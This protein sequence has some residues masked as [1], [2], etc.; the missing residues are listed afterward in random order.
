MISVQLAHFAPS[1]RRRFIPSRQDSKLRRILLIISPLTLLVRLCQSFHPY[2]KTSLRKSNPNVNQ[3]QQ[4]WTPSLLVLVCLD[5]LL[6]VLVNIINS[7]LRSAIVPKPLK[8]AVIKS[9]LNKN[10]LDSILWKTH[11]PVLNLPYVSKLLERVLAEQ[12]VCH[13]N[14]HDLLD[15]FQS[16]YRAGHSCEIAIPRVLN[17]VL[18]RADGGTWCFSFSWTSLLHLTPLTMKFSWRNCMR[19]WAFPVLLISGFVHIWLT[20]PSMSQ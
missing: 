19:R 12:L 15:K 20:E 4:V 8:T 10:G 14:Q 18:C 9:L 5:D 2:V 13:L 7:S 17:Y 6:P 1:L 11:R 3:H 16:A